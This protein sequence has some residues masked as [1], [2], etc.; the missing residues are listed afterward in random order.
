M[1]AAPK[2]EEAPDYEAEQAEN[3]WLK[4][5]PYEAVAMEEQQKASPVQPNKSAIIAA[6][7]NDIAH[8][9]IEQALQ[10]IQDF[11]AQSKSE[12]SG[13]YIGRVK[14]LRKQW[15]TLQK[16][17]FESYNS[18]SWDEYSSIADQVRKEILDLLASIEL[19]QKPEQVT[20][21]ASKTSK[22]EKTEP[23]PVDTP[24]SVTFEILELL[25][26]G[27]V[28]N[29]L[30]LLID[31]YQSMPDAPPVYLQT[32]RIIQADYY[33]NKADILKG[34][35]SSERAR[36]NELQTIRSVKELLLQQEQPAAMPTSAAP[37]FLSRIRKLF[38]GK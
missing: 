32:A 14:Q 12:W 36:L 2:K 20:N 11:A 7:R 8:D 29:A 9:R 10:N 28:E 23:P 27:Q 26:S 22:P 33:Q 5:D 1:V 3:D 6:A 38:T 16:Q 21:Y 15:E 25:N 37:G 19:N 24:K 4:N 13:H 17:F 31:H 30:T 35:I 34:T 18:R